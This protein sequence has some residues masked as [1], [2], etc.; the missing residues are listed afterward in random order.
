MK[1]RMKIKIKM[2]TKIKIKVIY[3][4]PFLCNNSNQM[5]RDFIGARP[6]KET[7]RKFVEKERKVKFSLF[8]LY[9]NL[10]FSYCFL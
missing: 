5:R 3:S 8:H 2:K 4:Y 7:H 6:I 9:Q 10:L 1:M